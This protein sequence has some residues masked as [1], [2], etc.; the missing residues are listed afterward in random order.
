MLRRVLQFSLHSNDAEDSN[1]QNNKS[2]AK[3]PNYYF[4]VSGN[5]E[6]YPKLNA[7]TINKI[8]I[9]QLVEL[10]KRGHKF[11]TSIVSSAR[12]KYTTS[13]NVNDAINSTIKLFLSQNNNDSIP[14]VVDQEFAMFWDTSC[15]HVKAFYRNILV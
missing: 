11:D 12:S 1:T 15:A 7:V 2:L 5:F 8:P 13:P 10:M 6:K 4:K 9:F 14:S 3:R